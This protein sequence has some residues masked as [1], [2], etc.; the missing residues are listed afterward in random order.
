MRRWIVLAVLLFAIAALD[1]Q[2]PTEL[3]GK[4]VVSR[5]LKTTTISCWGDKEGK[6]LIGTTIEYGL[7]SLRWQK[8]FIQDASVK[9]ETVSA[10]EF[11]RENSGGSANASRVTFHQLGIGSPTATVVEIA[12]PYAKLDQATGEVPGDRVLLKSNSVIVFSVCN[13]YFEAKR[14]PRR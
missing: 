1:Q 13:L 7:S 4:W 14:A 9:V 12:H 10:D 6:K 2:I 11:E 3:Q 5:V 8:T